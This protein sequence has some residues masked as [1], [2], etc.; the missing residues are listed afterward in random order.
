MFCF[1]FFGHETYGILA[2]RRGLKPISPALEGEILTSG[3]LGSPR[4]GSF[5]RSPSDLYGHKN[6]RNT[7]LDTFIQYL[8]TPYFKK[9][10]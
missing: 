9:L 3:P 2:P 6:L 1:F 7:V 4:N 5:T 10:I 8:L